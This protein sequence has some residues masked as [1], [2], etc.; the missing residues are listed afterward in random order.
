MRKKIDEIDDKLVLLLKDRMDLC[1]SIG[2]VKRELGAP[3][4][5][6]RREDEV[7]LHVMAKA[8]ECGLDPQKVEGIFKEIIALSVFVQGAE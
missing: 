8:L 1:K 5:D 2:E 6:R 4:K 3:V 7:Y